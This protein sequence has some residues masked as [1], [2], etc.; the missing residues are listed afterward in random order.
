M[1]T[2]NY[3]K[4]IKNLETQFTV[5]VPK[6]NGSEALPPSPRGSLSP[7]PTRNNPSP[8]PASNN[9]LITKENQSR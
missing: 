7:L 4:R 6:K 5:F 9:A 1:K 3:Q 8:A 2:Q